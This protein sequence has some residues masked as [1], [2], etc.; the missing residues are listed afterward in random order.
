MKSCG[1][2]GE[3]WREGSQPPGEDQRRSVAG[4]RSAT[5]HV[6]G[7]TPPLGRP[8]IAGRERDRTGERCPRALDSRSACDAHQQD[9]PAF[10]GLDDPSLNYD[11][12]RVAW[13]EW[14]HA[15]SIDRT[16][17]DDIAAGERYVELLPDALAMFVRRAGLPSPGIYARGRRG[18]LRDLDDPAATRNDRKT[19]LAPS[20][21]L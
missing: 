7:R 20:G 15:L 8:G 12:S 4:L 1:R 9:H 21:G 18:D 17:E 14:G 3:S 11:L 10:D 16:A 2:H 5:W 13:H 19:S 6:Y